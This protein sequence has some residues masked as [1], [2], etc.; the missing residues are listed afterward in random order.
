MKKAT[1][2]TTAIP[3]IATVL[4]LM[5]QRVASWGVKFYSLERLGG[6]GGWMQS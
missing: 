1:T 5:H 6:F 2:S 4:R 3:A